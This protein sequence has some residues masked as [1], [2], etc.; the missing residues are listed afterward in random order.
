MEDMGEIGLGEMQL[1]EKLKLVKIS[2]SLVE[3]KEEDQG[4]GQNGRNMGKI[5]GLGKEEKVKVKKRKEKMGRKDNY[6]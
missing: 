5:D 3:W 1:R 4:G 6:T 2:H